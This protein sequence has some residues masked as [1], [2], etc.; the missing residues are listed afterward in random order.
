[1]EPHIEEVGT[2]YVRNLYEELV[3]VLSH[4]LQHIKDLLST[5]VFTDHELE[6]RAEKTAIKR[7]KSWR[8]RKVPL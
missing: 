5:Q 3:V 1:M 7:L 2:I 4:E 6:V 8:T